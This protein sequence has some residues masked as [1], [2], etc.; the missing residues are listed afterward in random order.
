MVNKGMAR[1]LAFDPGYDR[2]GVAVI[3]RKNNKEHLV[4]SECV[5]TNR[6]DTMA[7]RLQH[8]GNRVDELL[9]EYTPTT[10]ALETLFFNKNQ[11]TG[12]AVAEVRGIILYL[13]LRSGCH[14]MEFNPQEIKVAV[15]GYGKSDKE[16]VIMMVKRLIAR[17]PTDAMDDEYDAIA[18]G[19]TALAHMR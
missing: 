2:L 12:I 18:V 16:A 19:I 7:E 11:K 15:T 10:V 5:G 6:N 17:V 4:Y 9:R 13:A 1:V 14:I 8:I 3:E